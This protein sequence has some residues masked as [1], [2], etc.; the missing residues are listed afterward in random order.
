MST[1]TLFSDTARDTALTTIGG[2]MMGTQD[3]ELLKQ[4]FVA[5]GNAVGGGTSTIQ[6]ET[7]EYLEAVV[8]AGGNI[9]GAVVNALDELICSAK[10]DAWWDNVLEAYPFCTDGFTGSMVKL[11]AA[12][13][14]PASL[15]N[16]SFVAADYSRGGGIGVESG[17]T[18]KWLQTGFTPSTLGYDRTNIGLIASI[19][20]ETVSAGA[21]SGRTI[22]DMISGN[23]G[24]CGIWFFHENTNLAVGNATYTSF[25][26]LNPTARVISFQSSGALHHTCTDG[27]Q[28]TNWAQTTTGTLTGEITLFRVTRFS[29]N[30]FENGKIGF[31]AITSYMTPTKAKLATAA[32]AKFERQIRS[33]YDTKDSGISLWGDSITATQGATLKSGGFAALVAS[34][35]GLRGVQYGNRSAWMTANSGPMGAVNQVAEIFARPERTVLMMFGTNDAQYSVT[36]TTYN[37]NLSTIIAAA[38]ANN[39]RRRLVLCTPCYTTTGANQTVLRTYATRLAAAAVTNGLTFADTNIAIADLA[40]PASAM[41]DATHPNTA[42]HLLMADVI[43]A[44]MRGQQLRRVI[45]DVPSLAAGASTSGTVTMLTARTGQAVTVTPPTTFDN[46]VVVTA[47]VSADDTVTYVVTNNT[48]GTVDEESGTF[49][50]VV[51]SAP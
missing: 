33:I 5:A 20:S 49:T 45:I 50:F 36:D 38:I 28:M 11:K 27:V 4:I 16:N 31:T 21:S 3:T 12:T 51:S 2:E 14:T 48:A 29:A 30:R 23:A 1:Y 42:G 43:T 26:A 39:A 6:V 18:T 44:A 7:Q 37:T 34:R 40:T 19:C 15:T 47:R 9:S 41:A 35:L 22:G 46:G 24:E 13:G 8:A 10:Q 17:N 32:V 25:Q